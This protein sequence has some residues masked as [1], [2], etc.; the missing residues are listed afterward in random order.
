MADEEIEV[1]VTEPTPDTGAAGGVLDL[2][3]AL[4]A[5]LKKALVHDGVARGL[6]ECVKALDRRTVRCVPSLAVLGSSNLRVKLINFLGTGPL[7]HFG[8]RLRLC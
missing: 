4:Q 5:A 1:A 2:N 7:V 3:G 6:R 8:R